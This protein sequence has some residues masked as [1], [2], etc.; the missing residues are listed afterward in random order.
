MY[1]DLLVENKDLDLRPSKKK[2]A[3]I[4]SPKH[5]TVIHSSEHHSPFMRSHEISQNTSEINI[6]EED[7]VKWVFE[8]SNQ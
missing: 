1:F 7:I 4:V 6:N 5:Q 2:G 8:K 3:K